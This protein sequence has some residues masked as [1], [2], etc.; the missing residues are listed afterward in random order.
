MQASFRRKFAK[1]SEMWTC[2]SLRLRIAKTIREGFS[3]L[4]QIIDNSNDQ[5]PQIK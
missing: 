5:L 2:H 1:D 3:L 4:K